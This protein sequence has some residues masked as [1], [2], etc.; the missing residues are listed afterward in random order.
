MVDVRAVLTRIADTMTHNLSHPNKRLTIT[1]DGDELVLPSQAATALA[2]ATNEL[3][4]NALEHAFVARD[5]GTVQVRLQEEEEQISVVVADDGVGLATA[6]AS[7]SGHSSL[8]LEIIRTLVTED[9][10]GTFT[11]TPTQDGTRAVI[12]LPRPGT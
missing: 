6:M 7:A 4:Q 12:R 9:L 10:H 1:V 3:I 2:L 8:G 5:K 11:L